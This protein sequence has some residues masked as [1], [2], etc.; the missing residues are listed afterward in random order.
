VHDVDDFDVLFVLLLF[1]FIIIRFYYYP[2]LL[3]FGN[4]LEVF[5][6]LGPNFLFVV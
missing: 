1:G 5:L 4:Q 3:L 6:G 2:V